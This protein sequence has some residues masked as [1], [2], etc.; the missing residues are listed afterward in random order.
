MIRRSFANRKIARGDL[1]GDPPSGTPAG[2]SLRLGRCQGPGTRHARPEDRA[3]RGS[4]AGAT[5]AEDGRGLTAP[6][7]RYWRCLGVP[8]GGF[9]VV[10]TTATTV[11][12]DSARSGTRPPSTRDHRAGQRSGR[13][14]KA[15][16]D[17]LRP[18]R[19]DDRAVS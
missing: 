14:A 17:E 9:S 2:V 15:G 19:L 7:L 13:H 16:Q 3:A 10:P 4:L 18:P 11:A 12:A 6:G 5:S 1:G 8:D